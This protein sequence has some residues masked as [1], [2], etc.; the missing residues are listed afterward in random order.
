MPEFNESI[1]ALLRRLL[2]ARSGNV[3]ALEELYHL[4]GV[5]NFV[6]I[7]ALTVLA[8]GLILA[9]VGFQGIRA[10][11]RAVDAEVARLAEATA[12]AASNEMEHYFQSFEDA[13]LNRLKSGESLGT[14]SRELSES[15]RIV[16]R[17]DA[18][19]KMTAPFAR[20]ELALDSDPLLPPSWLAGHRARARGDFY[21]AATLFSQAIRESH[22][23]R[24]TAIS[25]FERANAIYQTGDFTLAG[26]LFG[27]VLE[28]WGDIRD[29]YGFRLGDLARLRHAEILLAKNPTE[30]QTELQILLDELLL[31]TWQIGYGGEAAVARRA[32]DL[33]TPGGDPDQMSRLRIRLSERSTQLYHAEQLLNELDSL[34]ARGRLLKVSDGDFSYARTKMALWVTTW[35]ETDQFVM[36]LD[37]P[38]LL[39]RLRILA[40][41]TTTASSDVKVEVLPPDTSPAS[42]WLSRRS[43]SPWL[44]GW[45]LV[46]R[47]RDQASVAARKEEQWRRGVGI[48][49]FSMLMIG[50]G[51]VFSARLLQHEL[52]SAREKSDF[53]ARVSHEL[54]SPITQIRLKAE[55]LLL[56][57]APDEDSRNQHYGVIMR[58]SERLSRL[59][60]NM[61]DFAAIE[62]GLKRYSM[63]PGDLSQTVMKA[64]E[65][66]EGS[67][68]MAEMVVDLNLPDDL[69]PVWHDPDAVCQAITNLLS[70]AAKYGQ[71]AGWVGVAVRVVEGSVLVE[72]SDRGIGIAPEDQKRIFTEYYRSADPKAR[73][74]KGTGLGL[75]I[76]K[77]IVEAHGGHISVR[78]TPNVGS[79]FSLSFPTRPPENLPTNR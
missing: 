2:Q 56:G 49:G 43:L 17:F 67:I 57:L 59:V 52:N 53:A 48:I 28:K 76:V 5:L 75:T 19:G 26:Y 1:W 32:L 11:Q 42:D 37:L 35:T 77:Y 39:A 50:L 66:A 23:D 64:V 34:G 78:S 73:R 8:P 31:G 4:R 55:A 46:V 63:K 22:G 13:I 62:R 18:D 27:E 36:A 24:A 41:R 10:E 69:P 12:A 38:T 68:E 60:D 25:S 33:L 74:R 3:R 61:L 71:E 70:N 54:R 21:K 7:F 79:T 14:G 72:V 40:A 58:E 29:L 51:A 44:P 15:L 30:G 47:P 16:F 20:P 45:S 65:V 9:W 6:G